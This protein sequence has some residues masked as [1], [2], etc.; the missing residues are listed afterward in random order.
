MQKERIQLS[1]HFT[2]GRIMRFAIPSILMMLFISIYGMVDG[3]F[4]SNFAGDKAFTGVNIIWPWPMLLGAIGF[5][6]GA[7]G[8][9]LVGKTIGEGNLD[10]ARQYFTA[11]V[12]ATFSIGVVAAVSSDI[13]MPQICSLLGANEDTM[14]AAKVYGYFLCSS[15][16]FFMVQN[17]FQ[18]FLVAAEK[19]KIGLQVTLVAGLTNICL[20]ALFVAA[21]KWGVIG[22]AAAS[23]TSQVVGVTL[24]ILYFVSKNNDSLLKFTKPKIEIKNFLKV[25]V[26]GSSELLSNVSI[27][28][29]NI[30]YNLQLL[31]YIGDSGVAAY[32]VM[33]YICFFFMSIF[34]G[35]TVAMGPV[36]SFNYGSQN[37]DELHNIYKKGLF[38][39]GIFSIFMTILA[40]SLSRVFANI[41]VGYDQSLSDLTTKGFRLFAIGFLM[42]GFNVYSSAFFTSLNNGKISLIISFGRTLVFQLIALYSLPLL[43]DNHVL[44]IWLSFPTAEV[45]SIL[46]SFIFLLTQKKK[47]HY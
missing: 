47:Y 45:A 10:K 13:F 7:G 23:V 5:M 46:V 3:I 36:V 8:V 38:L 11:I 9:A 43:F 33:Q 20:D 29:V 35:Y 40:V 6:F 14:Y 18:N 30:L 37:N 15:I 42:M 16:P 21:F 27:S 25:I 26:N 39:M 32:G 12:I 28:L 44:G 1:D 34:F 4:V 31:K 24:P 17:L 19:P 22:A 41:Y 2:Y